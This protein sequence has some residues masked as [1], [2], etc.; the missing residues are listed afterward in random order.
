MYHD[1]K[2]HCGI[3]G[4]VIHPIEILMMDLTDL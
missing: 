1:Q 3:C 4:M 2:K